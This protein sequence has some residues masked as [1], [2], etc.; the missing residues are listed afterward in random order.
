[1]AELRRKDLS[2]NVVHATRAATLP[3]AIMPAIQAHLE[4]IGE[5]VLVAGDHR[6]AKV[7]VHNERPDAVIA[8][9]L[10]LGVLTLAVML[11]AIGAV[12][13]A[14]VGRAPR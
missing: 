14:R 3:S 1:M 4:T 11:L 7:H 6:M 13:G 12:V 8:Y 10:S 5:S 2:G 9:G